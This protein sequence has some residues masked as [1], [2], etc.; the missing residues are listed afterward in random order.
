MSLTLGQ[1]K[2]VARFLARQSHLCYTNV[3]TLSNIHL[4][5]LEGFPDSS[6]GVVVGG[7]EERLN[8]SREGTIISYTSISCICYTGA[9]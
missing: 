2:R 4:T 8:Y 5:T 6:F 7:M 1:K 9:G 3:P